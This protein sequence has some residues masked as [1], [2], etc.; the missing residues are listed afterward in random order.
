ML[1]L[2]EIE[3]LEDK[4][5]FK[6]LDCGIRVVHCPANS[7]FD[8]R[9][10]LSALIK[11]ELSCDGRFK[12]G[13]A[14]FLEHMMFR[15]SKNYPSFIQLA[16]AFEWLGGE[17][18]A[19]T[20]HEYTEYTFKGIADNIPKTIQLFADFL[21]HPLLLDIE[22]EREVILREIEEEINEFG[23][24]LDDEWHMSSLLWPD[25]WVAKPI[26]G[27]LDSVREISLENL[28][29][30]WQETYLPENMLLCIAGNCDFPQVF[31]TLNLLFADYG[32]GKTPSFQKE[33]ENKAPKTE[34]TKPIGY[35][36]DGPRF[37]LVRNSDSQYQLRMSFPCEG[38][39]SDEAI[40]YDVIC[41]I[42][43]DNYSSQLPLRLR[44]ELGLVYDVGCRAGL[45][46]QVGSIDITATI[47]IDKFYQF[48]TET[49]KV[50]KAFSTHGP[51]QKELAKNIHRSQ[52]DI[53][54]AAN[55]P[56]IIGTR[57]VWG[58]L[59][60]NGNKLSLEYTRLS[61]LT[62]EEIQRVAA[63]IFKPA[64]CGVV[65]LGPKDK[66]LKDDVMKIVN[67]YL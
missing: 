56:E 46:S 59:F 22:F 60:G 33:F 6:A 32:R 49:C 28:Q 10:F 8:N 37:K 38:E 48:L 44:E 23:N 63:K 34:E 20:G 58:E 35:I 41:R 2:S 12:D 3:M 13:I 51:T 39:W 47:T 67:T 5:E 43:A 15:G 29:Q 40:I 16:D 54:L 26:A 30:Y 14:H 21:V 18:N 19:E 57:A 42:L 53:S 24:S 55:D 9:L 1:N 36:E 65:V 17:W 62:I 61:S 27:S 7:K 45:L 4:C 11:S 52:I 64:N 66:S 31:S 50:L 25:T